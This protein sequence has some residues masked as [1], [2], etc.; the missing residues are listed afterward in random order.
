MHSFGVLELVSLPWV[1]VW[2]ALDSM[3]LGICVCVIEYY[4]VLRE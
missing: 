4:F 3:D 1:C 2:L